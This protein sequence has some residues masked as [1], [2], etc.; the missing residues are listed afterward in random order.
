MRRYEVELNIPADEML[1]YYRGGASSV[2]AR[3]RYGRRLQFPAVALRPFV[4]AAGVR[5]RFVL[6]VDDANRLERLERG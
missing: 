1:R 4:T 2:V 5:G 3:D 6:H